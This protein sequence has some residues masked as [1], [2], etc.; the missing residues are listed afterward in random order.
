MEQAIILTDTIAAPATAHGGALSIIRLSG[1]KAIEIADRLWH[2]R[3]PLTTL[4]PNTATYGRLH[5]ARGNELDEVM[6]TI[7]RAPHSFT[8]QDSVE[9]T[10][11]GSAWI[12]RA[13][14]DALTGAGATVAAPGE[15]TQRAFLNGRIDLT[16]AEGIA[17]LIASTSRASH[18][19][20][21]SQTR[22]DF[23]RRFN[24]LRD[25][26]IHIASMLELELDFGEEE[27]EFA[28]RTELT[29]LCNDTIK[30]I[31]SLASSY[32]TGRVLKE[33]VPVVIAGR[34][35]A[36]KSTLLNALLGDDKAIVSDIPGTTRDII[37]D[38]AEI[39]GILYRFIDTAGLRTDTT[40][41]IESQG[42]ER[43]RKALS[44]ARIILWLKDPA[45]TPANGVR[46]A[47]APDTMPTVDASPSQPTSDTVPTV[48][49]S[50]FPL[51]SD[52]VPTAE[53]DLPEN[54][55]ATTLYLL[56]KADLY[57]DLQA[58]S[59][60]IKISAKDERT[61]QRLKSE[62]KNIVMAGADP[63]E[64]L[65]ITNARHHAALREVSQALKS[66]IEALDA[67]ESPELVA[68]HI[69]RSIQHL[70][71]LTGAITPEDL[72]QNIFRNFCIGK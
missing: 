65:I 56:T 5:D 41:T 57:P 69:R 33:G 62:L 53:I 58:E 47:S 7:Y 23:S 32:A 3:H 50:P 49:A 21:L 8:G 67:D 28:D 42:M 15:F 24:A 35:N 43:A 40:D 34:P 31:D 26:L 17:D 38:T 68:Q 12:T 16:R 48:D 1:P 59:P 25:R 30:E 54:P 60:W 46:P 51:T 39:D 45:Q 36:G 20:A 14:M 52:T 37:E 61:V 27:V 11:H 70:G 64:T 72:L 4:P 13:V 10:L 19:I 55:E 63:G 44:Q 2:G 9:F 18:R 22:G 71:I 66:A 29:R 6:A